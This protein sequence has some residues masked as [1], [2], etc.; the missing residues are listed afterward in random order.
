MFTNISGGQEYFLYS[1][2]DSVK[3]RGATQAI[4]ITLKE[5]GSH[6][7]TGVL[8]IMDSHSLAGQVVLNDAGPIPPHTKIMLSREDAWDHQQ[9]ELDG[10]G[11]FSFQ[12]LPPEAYSLSLHIPG[13]A[14]SELNPSLDRYNPRSLI[15]RVDGDIRSLSIWMERPDA[16]RKPDPAAHFRALKES[17]WKQEKVQAAPLRGF[18]PP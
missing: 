15:G 6:L 13:Y 11:R 7:D 2:M 17:G 1:T 9:V 16:V 3:Q 14:I 4:V 5:P 8:P 12:D 10:T 18:A